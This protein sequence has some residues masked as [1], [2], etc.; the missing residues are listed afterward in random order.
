MWTKWAAAGLLVVFPSFAESLTVQVDPQQTQVDFTLHDV[1]HTVRGTF[2]LISGTI[3]FDPMTGSASGSLVID[4]KSGNSGSPARDS[5]M[6]KNI[7]E[8]DKYPQ[9][10]F[11]ADRV[12]G[13]VNL[14][15]PSDVQLHGIL[16]IHGA[17][18]ETTIRVHANLSSDRVT[19]T[20]QFLVPYVK[21][22][23]KNPS[24]FLL[25]VSDTVEIEI[26]AAGRL[27]SGS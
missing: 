10:T 26:H 3:Q 22:G 1:L 11:V 4:A 13:P 16:T 5:R 14:Q 6:H 20:A 19:A 7:L 21:W 23:M 24:T 8:S 27:G 2:R 15:G 17:P 9:I 18:H 25:R 12:A